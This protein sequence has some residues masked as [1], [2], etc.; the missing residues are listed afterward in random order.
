MPKKTIYISDADQPVWEQAEALAVKDSLSGVLTEAL[1]T[2]IQGRRALRADVRLEG[3]YKELRVR[4]EPT[5][6]GWLINVPA[7]TLP[8]QSTPADAARIL[9]ESEA[10]QSGDINF[11]WASDE[12]LWVWVSASKIRSLRFRIPRYVGGVDYTDA[13]RIAWPI[14]VKAAG[15]NTLITYGDLGASLGG[16]NP[17][18]QVPKVLDVIEQWC[19]SHNRSDLTGFVINKETG[20]PGVGYWKAH[21]AERLPIPEQVD[22]WEKDRAASSAADNWLDEAPF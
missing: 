22:L 21:K 16:L 1:R 7:E 11:D 15:T 20:L 4:V 8:G 14:L 3:T 2:Y 9:Q 18:T 13:A 19:Q 17:H 6:G 12:E 5:S 10:V